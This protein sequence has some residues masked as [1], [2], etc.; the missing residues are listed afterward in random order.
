MEIEKI[1]S[2]EQAKKVIQE[3][4]AKLKNTKDGI[5]KKNIRLAILD[6]KQ[7]AIS[8]EKKTISKEKNKMV[9]QAKKLNSATARKCR[10]HGL[11]CVALGVLYS[12]NKIADFEKACE[13]GNA[14][15][16]E[17]AKLNFGF[18][19]GTTK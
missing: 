7:K 16:E 9:Q 14:A 19:K 18:V 11:I 6:V 5:E 13:G 12:Q 2:I 8:L 4:N 10:N 15:I 1:E 3:L 17:F